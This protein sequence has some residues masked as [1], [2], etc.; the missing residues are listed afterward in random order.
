MFLIFVFWVV[1]KNIFYGFYGC[2]ELGVLAVLGG[3]VGDIALAGAARATLPAGAHLHRPHDAWRHPFGTLQHAASSATTGASAAPARHHQVF[4][5]EVPFLREGESAL[6][7]GEGVDLKSLVKTGRAAHEQRPGTW[8]A[9]DHNAGASAPSLLTFWIC[10]TSA[11]AGVGL[12]ICAIK[13][14][15]AVAAPPPSGAKMAAAATAALAPISATVMEVVGVSID[16][17]ASATGIPGRLKGQV[18]KNPISA[19]TT[20]VPGGGTFFSW[21]S[22]T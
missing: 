22:C 5:V 12:A 7:C 20:I 19:T 21:F 4:Q 14:G 16:S 13:G 2:S 15:P 11:T 18:A 10:S 6:A 17:A 3:L 9:D 1:L 8:I